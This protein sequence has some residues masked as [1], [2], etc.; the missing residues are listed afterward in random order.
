MAGPP[1]FGV[2]TWS[3]FVPLVRSPTVDPASIRLAVE[4]RSAARWAPGTALPDGPAKNCWSL[5]PLRA[6]GSLDPSDAAGGPRDAFGQLGPDFGPRSPPSAGAVAVRRPALPGGL[7]PV[8][9]KAVTWRWPALWRGG[10][11]PRRARPRFRSR[12][13][14]PGVCN[15]VHPRTIGRSRSMTRSPPCSPPP[16]RASS[17]ASWSVCCPPPSLADVPEH[18]W[19]QRLSVPR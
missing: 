4:P 7:Q 6:A 18:R 15:L 10:P 5:V 14:G 16:V 11:K 19:A 3:P 2:M 1:R 8:G 12:R 9:S 17:A 13:P